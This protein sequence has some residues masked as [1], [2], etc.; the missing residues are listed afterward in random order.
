[1]VHAVQVKTSPMNLRRQNPFKKLT[2]FSLY[3]KEK[4]CERFTSLKKKPHFT[5]KFPG[6]QNVCKNVF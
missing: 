1:M 4:I 2:N 3:L 6:R 5:P